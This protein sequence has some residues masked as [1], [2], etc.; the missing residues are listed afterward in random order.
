MPAF[1]LFSL[2]PALQTLRCLNCWLQGH[3]KPVDCWAF[4]VLLYEMVAGEARSTQAR[5]LSVM[6][7]SLQ[8]ALSTCE[9]VSSVQLLHEQQR[10]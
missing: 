3:G 2:W 10:S 5:R 8:K 4:G 9:A 7:R 6:R 1:H